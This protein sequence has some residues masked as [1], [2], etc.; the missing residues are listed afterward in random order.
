MKDIDAVTIAFM[1]LYVTW[2]EV[3][4]RLTSYRRAPSTGNGSYVTRTEY[5]NRHLELKEDLARIEAKLDAH[6]AKRP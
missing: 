6:I 3:I 5:E 2:K 1:A 4:P